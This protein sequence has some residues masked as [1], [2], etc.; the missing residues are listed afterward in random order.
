MIPSLSTKTVFSLL[1]LIGLLTGSFGLAQ[2]RPALVEEM[3]WADTVLING[4][5]VT[6]DDRT[7]T[8]DTPGNIYQAMAIKGKKIM[9][10]GTDV[11]MRRMAGKN[12]ELVDLGGRTTIPGLIQTHYHLFSSAAWKYGPQLGFT[13][14]S[15]KLNVMADTTV[16]GTAKRIRDTVVNAIQAQKIPEGQWIS[17]AVAESPDNP[18]GTNRTW[19]YV[20][21]LNRRQLD[22]VT[23]KHPV[24]VNSMIGG[25]FNQA[26]IDE[27]TKM[28]SDWAESTDLETGPGSAMNGYLAV[29]EQGAV[30]FEYWWKD[31]PLADLAEVMRLQGLDVIRSGITSVATRLLYPRTVAAFSLLNREERLPHRLAYYIESQRGNLFNQKSI[32]QFYRAYGAPWTDHKSGGEMMWLNGMCHEIWDSTQNNVCLGD[33]VDSTPDLKAR[34]RCPNP[35][36]KAWISLKAGLVNGW[37]A[38]QVHGTS[39]HG[40]RL[41]LQMLEEA[42]EEANLTVE[43]VRALRLTLEHNQVLGNLPDVMA[44]IK[45]Y[46]IILNPAPSLLSEIPKLIEDYGEQLR[47]F[48]MPV[49]SWIDQGIRVTFEASG[50]N[51]WGPIHTLVTR[52]TEINSWYKTSHVVLP[53]EAVDRVTALKMA[54]TWASEYLLAEDTIGTLEPGKYADFTVLDRD[55]FSIPADDIPNVKAVMTGLSGQVVYDVTSGVEMLAGGN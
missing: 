8:P 17:V 20:G 44:G 26:A 1:A 15:I 46:G 49:K 23:S 28:F 42:M 52:K 10:L 18:P 39:S 7:N 48:A 45:K 32:E 31:K 55:F 13:D 6:M 50:T 11:E 16:E 21:K 37:R 51:F 54:T 34:E 22:P 9:A 27:F 41:Y 24:I 4:R 25:Y 38:A 40:V 14:P 35:Q 2:D 47:P 5:I 36:L 30:T 53:E 12:T 43:D 29:P 3:G 19:L 33:D